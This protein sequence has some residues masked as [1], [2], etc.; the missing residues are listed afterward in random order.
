M[1]N[2]A[3]NA[4]ASWIP[5]IAVALS[6]FLISSDQLVLPVAAENIVADLNT[7]ASTIQAALAILGLIAAPLHF[8]GGKLGEIHGNKRIFLVGALLYLLASIAATLAPNAAV[9]LGGWSVLRGVALAC[10]IPTGLALLVSNYQASRRD[11][12]FS[13]YGIS[14]PAAALVMPIF[15]G[16]AASNLSW[17][18][19][20]GLH[21]LIALV[22]LFLT[23]RVVDTSRKE[24]VKMDWL[25][26]LLAFLGIGAL[27][28]G[29]MLA[30]N[31]G[32]WEAKR[33]FQL[34]GST[35]NPLGLSPVP[36]ILS[37]GVIMLA[38]LLNRNSS[39]AAHGEQPLFR[40]SIFDRRQFLTAWLGTMIFFLLVGALPFVVPIFLQGAAGYE[41][42]STGLVMAVFSLGSIA[43]GLA[44]GALVGRFHP[45]YVLQTFAI[46]TL[47]GLVWLFLNVGLDIPFWKIAL[48][49][50]VVGAG[51]GVLLSQTPNVSLSGVK[52]R[53]AGDAGAVQQSSNELSIGLGVAVI[54]SLFFSLVLNGFVDGVSQATNITLSDK[55]R[56]AVVVEMEDA[57]QSVSAGD[58]DQLFTVFPPVIQVQLNHVMEDSLIAAMQTVVGIMG[59]IVLLALSLFSF[60]PIVAEPD[61]PRKEQTAGHI[62]EHRLEVIS[63]RLVHVI[64]NPASGQDEPIL[65]ILNR[66]F[67]QANIEWELSL[68][69]KAGDGIRLAKEAVARGADLVVGYGGDG[70]QMEIA[71]GLVGTGI[72]MAILP[73]GTGNSMAHA[74]NVPSKLQPAA[75]LISQSHTTRA[76]DLAQIED[77]YF[78]LRANTGTEEKHKAT[79]E[80]KDR[81]GNLAYVIEGVRLLRGLK[82]VNYNLTIDGEHIEVEGLSCIIFNAGS[83]GQYGTLNA[84]IQVDDGLLDVLIINTS[85][86]STL[87][88]A[89]FALDIDGTQAGLHQWQG[90][91]ITV[92]ADPP[93]PLWVD[94]ELFGETP[95]TIKVVPNA[96]NILVPEV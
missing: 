49:M 39:L 28:L 46:V 12:A 35:I 56:S 33:P 69:R 20:F 92:R 36:L 9:F 11:Q 31:Y 73:G 3:R 7:R 75:E 61:Y 16:W 5:L 67:N 82:P 22:C 44:S 29:P 47:L 23:F 17:R 62:L 83:I 89:N 57:F 59:L 38:L 58:G 51:T 64:I 19:T 93:Q 84:S 79:R 86:E 96:V 76:I 1:S 2:N 70:T 13:I 21:A 6:M 66:V 53:E 25:G 24:G 68:T 43:L 72:P 45:R 91:E 87:A 90:R 65:N 40:L 80:E 60:I 78:M 4:S 8:V 32:W 54:G 94:G 81:Y 50:F 48:P 63:Y 88:L 34:A 77:H 10:L 74:L 41:P 26:A 37:F 71:N 42:L 14:G 30:G 55:Q 95:F 85:L 52:P 18:L 27:V 15:M